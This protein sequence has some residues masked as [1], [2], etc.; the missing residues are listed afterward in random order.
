MPKA[1]V[2]RCVASLDNDRRD[3]SNF[4]CVFVLPYFG[5]IVSSD[6]TYGHSFRLQA[7]FIGRQG[8]HIRK[9]KELCC[10]LDP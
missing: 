2:D 9:I 3:Y 10:P 7:I 1:V 4:K 8:A 5:D 6:S